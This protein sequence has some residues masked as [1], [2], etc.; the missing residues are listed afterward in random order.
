MW[1]YNKKGVLAMK[2]ALLVIDYTVDFVASDGKLTCGEPGQR[3]APYITHLMEKFIKANDTIFII[4]DL[5]EATDSFHP[6]HALFP[7]HNI[8]GTAGRHLYGT[9]AEVLMK[10]Q[11][12]IIQLDKTRYSAFCGTPLFT[13]LRERQIETLQIVGV[14]TDICVLHTCI[15][16]YN[17]GYDVVIHE[18]GVASFN[19]EAHHFALA[20][21]KNS[22]GFTIL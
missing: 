7:P 2:N 1:H 14:C 12:V 8:R 21:I 17:L 20:H 13:K 19:E 22:L 4:N 10:H 9:T 11:D 6:E 15:D 3:L 18:R 16:A 5:H